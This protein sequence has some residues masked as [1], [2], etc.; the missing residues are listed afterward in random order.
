M[1]WKPGD[2]AIIGASAGINPLYRY[3]VGSE[4]LLI[5]Y[6]GDRIDAD[7]KD[8]PNAWKIEIAGMPW[9]AAQSVLRKPY[10]GHKPCEWEDCI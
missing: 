5:K 7:G 9:Y 4:C 6:L 2:I 8:V 10:D 3:A 1:N